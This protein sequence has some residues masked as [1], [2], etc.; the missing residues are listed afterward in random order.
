MSLV[1]LG[2]LYQL[3]KSE[4]PFFLDLMGLPSVWRRYMA[5]RM[6]SLSWTD[7]S[8]ILLL[9]VATVITTSGTNTAQAPSGLNWRI[10][11]RFLRGFVKKDRWGFLIPFSV[12]V[13][14]QSSTAAFSQ[15][16]SMYQIFYQLPCLRLF[17][18]RIPI[19]IESY[20]TH[21]PLKLI[22]VYWKGIEVGVCNL[23]PVAEPSQNKRKGA[24]SLV[25]R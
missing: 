16:S 10:Y 18:C 2:N 23:W 15:P 1:T 13:E 6:R 5:F 22:Q 3:I 14:G 7:Q 25:N 9:M 4:I 11:M 19:P 12:S 8:G 21:S 24:R 20:Y 17:P